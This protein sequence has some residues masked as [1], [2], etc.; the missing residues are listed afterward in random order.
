MG[1]LIPTLLVIMLSFLVVRAAA[2]ALMITGMDQARARFQ[3]L[4]AFSGTGFT[5][6][7]AEAIVNHPQRRQIATWLMILGN[8]GIVTV[9]VTATSSVVTTRGYQLGITIAVLI[10]GTYL[11]VW[12]GRHRGLARRWESFVERRFIKSRFFKGRVLE[13]LIDVGGDY[14]IAR[15]F[16]TAK[17]A[18]EGMTI[19]QAGLQEHESYLLGIERGQDWIP[20]PGAEE[21]L[22]A[23]DSLVV[24]G[25]A[26]KLKDGLPFTQPR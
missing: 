3:A 5:T 22:Q 14:R 6:R 23:G 1:F 13:N 4:S 9:I 26:G 24:V 20:F 7:E 10:L 15:V 16:V 8:A 19:S 12:L 2:I 21:V 17:S 11:I 25:E 18:L